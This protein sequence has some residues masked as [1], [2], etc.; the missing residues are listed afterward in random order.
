[1][2]SMNALRTFVVDDEPVARR[3]LL[4]ELREID[5]VEIVGE[6]ENG[7]Q[8]LDRIRRLE[9]DL[10]LLDI[11]M[12]VLDGFDVIRG[13]DG[14]LPSLV[15]VTAYSEHALRAFE[16]GV[17][18]Y[19]LKPVAPERLR[20]AVERARQARSR[21]L[22]AAESVARTLNAASPSPPGKSARIVARRGREYHLLS[23]D[24]VYAFQAD[25]EIVWIFTADKKYAATQTVKALEERLTGA[26][27]RRVRRGV[28]INA[29]KIRKLNRLS[30]QRWQVTLANGL[31]FA[32][33][34]RLAPE[35][36]KTLR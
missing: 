23:L 10:V 27:F 5:G 16:V 13:L 30:S 24:E 8:A 31:E 18:D 32:V 28:L 21:P 12:P 19:L 7:R 6:A 22:K 14:P 11:Q 1:M 34:K 29:D 33:S 9:P 35:V 15:F 36:W 20:A 3:V 4:D 26:N 17:C 25:R 2:P